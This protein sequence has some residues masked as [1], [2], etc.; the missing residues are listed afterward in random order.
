[1]GEDSNLDVA[2]D[3]LERM[4]DRQLSSIDALSTKVSVFLGFILT[5]FAALFGIAR[6]EIGSHLL[7]AA[8]A[9][10]LLLAAAVQL[11]LSYRMR[12]YLD[13]PAPDWLVSALDQAS[14][15]LKRDLI[16]NLAGAYASNR[17]AI[18]RQFGSFNR[19]IPLF[20]GGVILFVVGVWA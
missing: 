11:G 15:R 20:F 9:A 2:I 5:S 14:P 16:E 3:L 6:E 7:A 4:I 10:T 12:A 17:Q 8:L 19:S 18:R 1:M 13:A